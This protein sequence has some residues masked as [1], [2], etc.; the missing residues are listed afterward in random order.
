MHFCSQ[1]TGSKISKNTIRHSFQ[2][3]IV[4]HGT[5][6]LEVSENVAFDTAGH[7]FFTEDG[8]ETNNKFLRNLGAQTAA[9]SRILVNQDVEESDSEPATFWMSNP[10]NIL[11]GNVAAGSQSSGFW[12]EPVLRGDRA[13]QFKDEGYDPRY[14]PLGVF[15]G[16]VAHSTGDPN[17]DKNDVG[18]VRTYASDHFHEPRTPAIFRNMKVY[19]NNNIVCSSFRIV[20]QFPAPV[21]QDSHLYFFCNV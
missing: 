14:E 7:C 12:I 3:C 20:S 4:V 8:I 11:E 15:D 19:R 18:A 10:N 5:N 21:F 9:P 1:A 6:E 2:R 16:N 13:D 17:D